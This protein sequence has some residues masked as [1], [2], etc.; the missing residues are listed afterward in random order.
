[1]PAHVDLAG[2]E[3]PHV[4]VAVIG[5][6]FAGLGMA[7]RLKQA[8]VDDFV[9][10]ERADE[11]GGT[12]RDNTYP[13]AACD[14]PS[15][16][17][18]FSF[19]PNPHWSRSFSGQ[20]EIQAYLRGCAARF[21]VRPHI[22]FGHDVLAC[23]WDDAAQHWHIRTSRGDC[24]AAV[25]VSGTGA[26]SEPSLPSL[27]GLEDFTGTVFHSAQW[28]HDH[29]LTG[30]RVA[31]VGT[32]ASA[33]QIVPQIAGRVAQLD[34]YQRTPSWILPRTDRRIRRA[35]QELY[36]RLPALQRLVRAG[37]LAGREAY[38]P[39]FTHPRLLARL[40]EA[41]A[42]RHLHR[43]VRD[44][45]L[46]AGLTPDYT[47]GCKR[48]LLSNDFYPCLAR[49]NVELVTG[50]VTAVRSGSVVDS[51]GVSRPADTII[52]ATGFHVTDF[53]AGRRIVGR[54]G[55]SL[56][57]T[58]AGGMRAH[59]GSTVTGFP[60][61]FLLVGPNTGLG[62]TSMVIMI[63]AQIAYVM[64]ALR[65]L[66]QAGLSSVEVRPAALEV[67]NAR[68]QEQMRDTVWTTG[69]CAS[70][71]LDDAGRNTTLWPTFTWRFRRQTRRFDAE[72]YRARR[73][74]GVHQPLPAAGAR[75]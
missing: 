61:L 67:Y 47:I 66:R 71:Y 60:N 31:V 16:L 22:R 49:P 73:H 70:W 33:V 19:A 59:L 10:F 8:G 11:V 17:Y 4:R 24:T 48:I 56:A 1:M 23:R 27:P 38:V 36:R 26:L 46:R 21:G 57:E 51:A 45:A 37:I 62:H 72:S 69:G 29:D 32:G 30:R 34:L 2:A 20:P 15:H 13:G 7:I 5:T 55:R 54:D 18:S 39:G 58:W 65:H 28:D 9:V 14:V 52:F 42:R 50:A 74:A 41:L 64:D 63:E 3:P 25:L 40:P 75:A 12:W 68:L 44:P 6:G 35:E 53:P 43:Q